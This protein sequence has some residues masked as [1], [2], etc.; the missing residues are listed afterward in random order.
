MAIAPGRKMRELFEDPAAGGF[1][2]TAAGDQQ[3]GA[4]YEGRLRRRGA[5]R[6][7]RRAAGS[8]APRALHRSRGLSRSGRANASGAG[9]EDHQQPVA[10]PQML[11]ALDYYLANAARRSSIAGDHRDCS[12]DH[13]R[14]RSCRTPSRCVGRAPR[15]GTFQPPQ[16]MPEIDGK[17]TAYV[18]ENYACHLPTNQLSKFDEL[19]Q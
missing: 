11:V 7:R 3:S 5:F 13:I 9:L 18:C 12:C 1:F 14:A 8:A 16:T 19:L 17:P 2:S 10:V 15:F 4:A 6:E